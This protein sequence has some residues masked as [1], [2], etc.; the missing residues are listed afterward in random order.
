MSKG[1][2]VDTTQPPKL[3]FPVPD[4]IS[5]AILIGGLIVFCASVWFSV[6]RNLDFPWTSIRLAP[7]FALTQGYP[8]YSM[9][10][11]APWVMVVYGP[12]YPVMY[13]PATLAGSPLPAV[14]VA[15]LLAHLYVLV[16]VGFL[17]VDCSRRLRLEGA[18]LQ[19]HWS[20]ILFLFA[21]VAFAVPS[22][23]YVTTHV[24]VDAPAFGFFLSAAYCVLRA[25]SEMGN[26]V[27]WILLAGACAG[28]SA[29]C[30]MNL[31][32]ATLGFF[33]WLF[34]FRGAKH[35]LTFLSV[36]ALGFC[37][38]YA[39]A[40]LRDGL[41][42]V[43]LNLRLPAK[44]PWFTFQE[45]GTL[46]LSGS[47]HDLVAKFHTFLTFT[48][49]YLRDYGIV[50]LALLLLLPALEQKSAS[51]TQL[52]KFFLFLAVVMVLASIVSIGKAGGDVNS[53]ALVSLPL[54]L[55]AVLA[56]AILLQQ[57]RRSVMV[58]GL[59]TFTA[60][61]FIVALASVGGLLRLSLKGN[62]TLTEAYKTVSTGG[63]RWYFP[64]DP[65]AHLLAEKKF[66]PNMDVVH[67]YAMA[68]VPVDNAAFRS[69]LPENLEYVAFPPQFV[70]WGA[71]E[72][73]RL[74]PEYSRVVSTPPLE[75]H[76]VVTR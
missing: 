8:L 57:A 46:S 53:R 21:L 47:S 54:A 25:Q 56:F 63:S 75:N 69:A 9:P 76:Q 20:L 43:L 19:L 14:T 72:I 70:S 51:A 12:L 7:A 33:I 23:N 74:L 28:L 10:D 59:A 38:I 61:I 4:W 71:D 31:A 35:A 55:A 5:R 29:A 68:G 40:A 64:F 62:T 3:A 11:A 27:R 18:A 50:A 15:T 22:L 52:V 60:L 42:P 67:S 32:V 13:L 16:P 34:R 58:A 48:S 36:S 24:H 39:G 26:S 41:A 44:M 30:K 65:L 73:I 6:V 45:L 1:R 66:P 17:C 2:T 37:A 49:S